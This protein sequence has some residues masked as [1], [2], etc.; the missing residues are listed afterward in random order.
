M[1]Y[2][3]HGSIK[4][5]WLRQSFTLTTVGFEWQSFFGPKQTI[6]FEQFF[7]SEAK[8]REAITGLPAK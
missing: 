8:L 7:M 5:P 3:Y 6:T 1:G 4:T 2:L